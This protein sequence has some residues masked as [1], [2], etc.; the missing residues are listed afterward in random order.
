MAVCPR[1]RG[2]AT[3]LLFPDSCILFPVSGLR[4]PA[5]SFCSSS[6][7]TGVRSGRTRPRLAT[8][9]C[10][11][12]PFSGATPA[13]RTTL[14]TR[15]R[16]SRS[17]SSR[18]RSRTVRIFVVCGGSGMGEGCVVWWC[19]GVLVCGGGDVWCGGALEP[20]VY[21][22]GHAAH[23][24]NPHLTLTRIDLNTGFKSTKHACVQ[25]YQA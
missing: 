3:G 15:S 4:F 11:S 14:R 8:C 20:R 23:T 17:A 25:E 19:V 1:T 18:P 24:R 2:A 16:R 9:F 10:P 6:S 12:C 7:R 13:L 22:C 21:G 5:R